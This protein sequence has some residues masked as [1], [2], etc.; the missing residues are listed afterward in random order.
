MKKELIF[1]LHW[2]KGNIKKCRQT[3]YWS[4]WSMSMWYKSIIDEKCLNVEKS[5]AIKKKTKFKKKGIE[6]ICPL[7]RRLDLPPSF[8]WSMLIENTRNCEYSK[9]LFCFWQINSLFMFTNQT[10][11]T[12]SRTFV[13]QFLS[14]SIVEKLFHIKYNPV[15]QYLT[16]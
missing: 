13:C 7:S 16:V 15:N 14:Q 10:W 3:E 5:V 9:F 1:Y 12:S 4:G 8:W 6:S 2:N 11:W